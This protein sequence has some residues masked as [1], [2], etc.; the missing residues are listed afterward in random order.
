MTLLLRPLGVDTLAVAVWQRTTEGL[1]EAAAV[2][3]LTIVAAG[4]LP[5]A[6]LHRLGHASRTRPGAAA[7]AR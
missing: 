7:A 6:F 5:V 3:S 2:P 1:W 4:L